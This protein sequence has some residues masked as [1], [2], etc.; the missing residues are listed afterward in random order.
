MRVIGLRN[1]QMVPT[2]DSGTLA[3]AEQLDTIF[4]VASSVRDHLDGLVAA[5]AQNTLLV[6]RS[7]QLLETLAG[8]L[9]HIE[10]QVAKVDQRTRY[11][12]PEHTHEVRNFVD[13]IAYT[14][15]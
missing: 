10:T 15:V 14:L 12:M 11:L 2:Q 13:R 7:V 8:R 5:Q 3:L 6:E 1:A 9:E 4:D